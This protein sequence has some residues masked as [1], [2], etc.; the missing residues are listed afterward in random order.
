MTEQES[1]SKK[2]AVLSIMIEPVLSSLAFSFKHDWRKVLTY[3]L[4]KNK[5]MLPTALLLNPDKTFNSF[6]FEAQ[7]EYSTLDEESTDHYYF[8]DFVKHLIEFHECGS[9]SPSIKD[10]RG[11]K[12]NAKQLLSHSIRY[13]VDQFMSKVNDLSLGFWSIDMDVVLVLPCQCSSGLKDFFKDAAIEAGLAKDQ[14]SLVAGPVAAA[15]FYEH[16]TQDEIQYTL[17]T[18]GG[19]SISTLV[20]KSIYLSVHIGEENTTICAHLK[21]ARGIDPVLKTT[22]CP[23][24]MASIVCKVSSVLKNIFGDDVIEEFKKDY[25]MEFTSFVDNILLRPTKRERLTHVPS[26]LISLVEELH[27]KKFSDILESRHEEGKFVSFSCGKMSI[28]P[29]VK[30]QLFLPTIERIVEEIEIFIEKESLLNIEGI[31]F[32]GKLANCKPLQEL[33]KTKQKLKTIIFRDP[34][35][36]ILKGAV[37][38]GHLNKTK[39]IVASYTYGIQF[40]EDFDS[41]KHPEEKKFAIGGKEYCGE[42]FHVFVEKG[43][44]LPQEQFI[45]HRIRALNPKEE[46]FR[47]FI[48]KSQKRSPRFVDDPSC[49]KLGLIEVPFSKIPTDCYEETEIT[50]R[51]DFSG[52]SVEAYHIYKSHSFKVSLYDTDCIAC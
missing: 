49:F 27:G 45:Q 31:F 46:M 37:F 34:S 16:S 5:E 8:P 23:K 6:G 7:E 13:F 29:V 4:Q 24:G 32:S 26:D 43:D 30:D 22:D 36:I 33:L 41:T 18:N 28:L 14:I 44:L 42:V 19:F 12:V 17:V 38:Y 25:P 10:V 47:C 20:E 52:L 39:N 51:F 2:C 3:R 11:K 40:W 1:V 15:L 21:Y 48:F 50:M 35:M 9:H